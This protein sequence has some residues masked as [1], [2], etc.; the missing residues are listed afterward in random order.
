MAVNSGHDKIEDE[1]MKKLPHLNRN[2]PDSQNLS[3]K[4]HVGASSQFPAILDSLSL[5][6]AVGATFSLN[7]TKIL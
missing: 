5:R 6:T 7:K 4:T 2:P 1:V 3:S